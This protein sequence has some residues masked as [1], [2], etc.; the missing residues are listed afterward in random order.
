[1][2]QTTARRSF[3]PRP[4]T[5]KGVEMRSRLEARYAAWLDKHGF[6]W[7]YE[8]KCFAT[9]EGQYLPDFRIT[10]HFAGQDRTAYIEVKPTWAR[11]REANIRGCAEI[12]WASDPEALFINEI[13]ESEWSMLFL[14]PRWGVSG[15]FDIEWI[16]REGATPALG[17]TA[18]RTW[19]ED[20]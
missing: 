19:T 6:D 10:V 11:S 9:D 14:P 5:Y 7:E 20:Y 4:T 18:A 2:A 16:A 8:P 1:M 15:S 12:I 13:A 17:F 3:T